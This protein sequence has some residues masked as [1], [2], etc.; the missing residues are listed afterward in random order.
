VD[1]NVTFVQKKLLSFVSILPSD[2]FMAMW[3]VDCCIVSALECS[4][5][6]INFYGCHVVLMYVGGTYK[7]TPIHVYVHLKF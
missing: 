2:I 1:G 5:S 4:T 7:M 3:D 6:L